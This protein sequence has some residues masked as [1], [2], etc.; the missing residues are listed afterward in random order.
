MGS[1]R[2]W[3][4]VKG[5]GVSLTK[6]LEYTTKYIIQKLESYKT[7]LIASAYDLPNI[8]INKLQARPMKRI[9]TINP[10]IENQDK[11]I[12]FQPKR[13]SKKSLQHRESLSSLFQSSITFIRLQFDLPR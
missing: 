11:R 2:R 7:P 13:A 1:F 4:L 8:T 10:R 9:K 5:K 12:L 3:I 6:V